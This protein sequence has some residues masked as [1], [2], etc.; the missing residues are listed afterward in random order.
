MAG[1]ITTNLQHKMKENT[2]NGWTNYET[3]NAALWLGNGEGSSRY[4]DDLA[5]ESYD[6]AEA[7]DTFTRMENATFSL[8]DSIKDIFDSDERLPETGW[9]ADAVNTYISEVNWHEIAEHYMENVEQEQ[10]ETQEV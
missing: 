9:M 1:T 3:W 2:Y 10:E 8:A 7:C 6:N 4:C 5:Q